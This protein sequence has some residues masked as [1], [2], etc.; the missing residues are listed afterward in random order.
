MNNVKLLLPQDVQDQLLGLAF[1][2]DASLKKASSYLTQDVCNKY[3]DVKKDDVPNFSLLSKIVQEFKESNVKDDYSKAIIRAYE[4]TK[5]YQLLERTIFTLNSLKKNYNSDNV[6]NCVC[7]LDKILLGLMKNNVSPT[8]EEIKDYLKSNNIEKLKDFKEF[9]GIEDIKLFN[10]VNRL[11]FGRVAHC[12]DKELGALSRDLEGWF[13]TNLDQRNR[14]VFRELSLGSTED[15][16]VF[17]AVAN[18]WGHYDGDKNT[19]NRNGI[20]SRVD[21]FNNIDL[22]DLSVLVTSSEQLV[23]S[24]SQNIQ[25][26]S[27]HFDKSDE[28]LFITDIQDLYKESKRYIK[29][30]L[31]TQDI[32]EK[33]IVKKR[34]NELIGDKLEHCLSGV[35]NI[36]LYLTDVNFQ[37]DENKSK[38]I[39]SLSELEKLH[40]V[41]LSNFV[42]C[43][44]QYVSFYEIPNQKTPVDVM[45]GV[46]GSCD[47]AMSLVNEYKDK[48][49]KEDVDI[50][51]FVN[52][53]NKAMNN[54]LFKLSSKIDESNLSKTLTNLGSYKF[55]NIDK[56]NIF[57]S[58]I[59]FLD[60]KLVS[61]ISVPKP[62][63]IYFNIPSE[64]QKEAKKLGI[65][66]DRNTKSWYVPQGKDLTPFDKRW[67]R[68]DESTIELTKN[69]KQQRDKLRKELK[70]EKDNQNQKITQSNSIDSAKKKGRSR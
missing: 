19:F 40:I 14:L 1:F 63:N 7:D 53:L 38:K 24:I 29:Q 39:E 9:T 61:S 70:V 47:R 2:S 37:N 41:T 67:K 60:S 3:P 26:D 11:P 56:K 49:F 15:S 23:S 22:S 58:A 48:E 32:D 54:D 46:I 21:Y 44:N 66:W 62:L 64:E 12:N 59:S 65:K 17:I 16:T 43:V 30:I 50:T 25:A 8:N 42:S 52:D 33:N 36:S 18:I 13:V 5:P 69:E 4:C 45:N 28:D 10:P 35:L 51:S 27:L 55:N 20:E 68:I 57:P 6:F 31:E 34:L